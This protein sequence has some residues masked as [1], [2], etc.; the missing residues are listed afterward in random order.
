[1]SKAWAGIAL[2]GSSATLLCCV[3]PVLL[4]A[5]G[6]GASVAGAFAALPQLALIGEHK[7]IIFTVAGM[8]VGSAF[9]MRS[10]PAAQVCPVDPVLA[11][12][13]MKTR[14]LSTIFLC[15]AT[16][17]YVGALFFVYALPHLL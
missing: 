1:M 3:I 15:T 13:C 4:V 12:A 2:L 17:I 9:W 7:G 6:F 8:L 10:R 5:L 11:A 16:L 14:K